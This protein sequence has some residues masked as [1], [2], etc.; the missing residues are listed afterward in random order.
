MSSESSHTEFLESLSPLSSARSLRATKVY[1][2][3][4]VARTDL[5]LESGASQR[6]LSIPRVRYLYVLSLSKSLTRFNLDTYA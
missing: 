3:R 4:F 2:H 1:Q 6:C 5:A